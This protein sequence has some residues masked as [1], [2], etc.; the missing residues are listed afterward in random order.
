[1][2]NHVTHI[3]VQNAFRGV[4]RVTGTDFS[5]KT[6]CRFKVTLDFHG[7][8]VTVQQRKSDGVLFVNCAGRCAIIGRNPLSIRNSV[9]QALRAQK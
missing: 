5:T 2:R 6:G 1:M 8:V 4:A 3:D 7:K 9:V